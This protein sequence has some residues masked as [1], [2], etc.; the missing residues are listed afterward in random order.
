[1]AVESK[2]V[3]PLAR[4][5]HEVTSPAEP[6]RTRRRSDAGDA[7]MASSR[8]GAPL[9]TSPPVVRSSPGAAWLSRRDRGAELLLAFFGATV[10]MVVAVVLVGA[11]DQWWALA[12]VMLVHL[13]VTF[14]VIGTIVHMLGG[15][16]ELL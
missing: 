2:P 8:F 16:G 14:A 7:T 9:P 10:I 6:A 4:G 5:R 13:V 1:V 12:P 15:D 3:R 11:V